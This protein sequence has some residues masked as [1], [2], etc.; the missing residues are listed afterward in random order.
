MLAWSLRDKVFSFFSPSRTSEP[1]SLPSEQCGRIGKQED[2]ENP[3]FNKQAN[4]AQHVQ[5]QDG[6]W[7]EMKAQLNLEYN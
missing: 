7:S 5:E 6:K 2:Y 3:S 4:K 1:R